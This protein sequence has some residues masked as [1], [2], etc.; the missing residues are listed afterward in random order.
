MKGEGEGEGERGCRCPRVLAG[1]AET[2]SRVLNE[3]CP[4]HGVGTAYWQ[5]LERLP[6][7]Y[8]RERRTSRKEWIAWRA[9]CGVVLDA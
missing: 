6:F 8:E 9:S 3:D 7:G 4:V 1:G 2:G 5:A